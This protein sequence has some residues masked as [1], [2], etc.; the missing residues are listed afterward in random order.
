MRARVLNLLAGLAFMAIVSS[1]AWSIEPETVGKTTMEEPTAK[2][3]IVKAAFGA[4]YVF[5][6]E[7][8]EMQGL[9]SLSTFTPAV[10][11]NLKRNEVYAAETYYSRGYHGER[12]DVL[13][14]YDLET[15]SPG[16]EIDIPKK[17]ATLSFRQYIALLDDDRHLAIFNMTPAQSV[18]IVDV[19]SREF[20]GEISTPG[21]ALML[22][23]AHRA[24]LMMCGD[25]TLQLVGLDR[26]GS[27]SR[28]IRSDAFFE[29]DD[30]PVFD[31]PVPTEDGWQLVSF[32]GKVFEVTVDDDSIQISEP[33]SVLSE[34]DREQTWRV[35]GGQLMD[36]HVGLD[37][38]F[39]MMHQGEIDTHEEP[40]TEIWIFDRGTQRRIARIE[41]GEPITN[42]LVSQ[43]DDPILIVS[44]EAGPLHIYDVKTAK[45]VRTIE[46]AG[47]FP[48]LLQRF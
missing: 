48:S 34:E 9:M 14:I 39:M 12:T 28:R 29:I 46:N 16:F 20:V 15:L 23:V 45:K 41:T 44:S 21:C 8:G 27:E 43:D 1:V 37:L 36:V 13:T 42:L 11:P 24:F 18:T 31:K 10:Q 25:G 4:G 38:L 2:W 32:E 33:W 22:P 35:G 26:N 17:V 19:R 6:G 30:D 40:G 7:S 47:P 3:F 5:D